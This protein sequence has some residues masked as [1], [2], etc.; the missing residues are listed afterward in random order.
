[1]ADIEAVKPHVEQG[2][3]LFAEWEKSTKDDRDTARELTEVYEA[4][5]DA[6]FISPFECHAYSLE[7][8]ALATKHRADVMT[9]HNKLVRRCVELGIDVPAPTDPGIPQPNSGGGTR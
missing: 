5:R 1:M 7:T 6:G 3:E 4:I 8:V 9:L 2:A